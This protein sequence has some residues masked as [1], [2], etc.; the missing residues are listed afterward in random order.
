MTSRQR[1]AIWRL[2]TRGSALALTQSAEV[3]RS[4]TAVSGKP[5]QL[6]EVAT[7]GDSSPRPLPEIGGTGVFVSAL[8]EALLAD[9]IDLAVH[10]LKDLPTAATAGLRVS[11]VPARADARD[12]LVAREAESLAGLPT[13]ARVGTGSPRRAALLH[14]LRPDLRVEQVRGNVDTRLRKLAAGEY[15]ALVLAAAGLERLG[16]LEVVTEWF[17]PSVVL[18]APGQG[19]LAVETR[20]DIDDDMPGL[21]TAL[22]AI[23]HPATRSAVTAERSLL[24]ALEAGCTAPVGAL[25][26]VDEPGFHTPELTLRAFVGATDGRAASRMSLTAPVA[27]AESA[28]RQLAASLLESGVVVA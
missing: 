21:A 17:D 12:V 23:D 27:E 24:S 26:V 25:A 20:D 10:S 8:R 22:V 11:A 1:P 18:P 19:A 3:A 28:G 5:V 2:G 6:V 16:R 7:P 4:L 15:D 13:D 14:E 9:R